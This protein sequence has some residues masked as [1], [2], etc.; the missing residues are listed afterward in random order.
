MGNGKPPKCNEIN[1]P[2]F[3]YCSNCTVPRDIC[4]PV[5]TQTS[6]YVDGRLY[7]F[8]VWTGR[9]RICLNVIQGFAVIPAVLGRDRLCV[10]CQSQLRPPKRR[11]SPGSI[12][13]PPAKSPVPVA[14]T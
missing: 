12:T 8:N 6:V 3:V 11:R 2:L 13:P 5:S 7:V 1:N 4:G 9:C 10:N 14:P